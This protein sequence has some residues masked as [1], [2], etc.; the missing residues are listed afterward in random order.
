MVDE[1]WRL[2]QGDQSHEVTLNL[3]PPVPP[4]QQK[5]VVADRERAVFVGRNEF[6]A[7]V[8]VTEVRLRSSQPKGSMPPSRIQ[9]ALLPKED[10]PPTTRRAPR[11][12]VAGVG[13]FA[14]AA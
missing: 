8:I 6:K 3:E 2:L 14:A 7:H 4:N 5:K 12:A 9:S 11:T 13:P 10:S 1:P